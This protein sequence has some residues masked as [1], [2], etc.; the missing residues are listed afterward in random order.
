MRRPAPGEWGYCYRPFVT[1][2]YK[3]LVQYIKIKELDLS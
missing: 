2:G 1:F 3:Y